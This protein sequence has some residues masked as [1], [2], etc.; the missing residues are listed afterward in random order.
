M[1]RARK[2]SESSRA[3]AP[4]KEA[5]VSAPAGGGS[6]PLSRRKRVAFTLVMSLVPLLFFALLEGGL[7]VFGYGGDYPLF[8]EADGFSHLLVQNRE[9]ARRYFVHQRNVPN[10]NADYFAREKP[11]GALR[12]VA[13]GESSTAGFPF[14]WG[15]AFPRILGNRL[16]AAYPEREV[17]VINTAMAAINSYTLLDFADEVIAIRP[18]AVVIYAGHNEYYG[19]LGAASSESLGGSPGVVRAFLSLRGFRT[20]QLLRDAAAAVQRGGARGNRPD[21]TLMA[22]MIGEQAV[23]IGGSTYRAG[24]RQF[25]ENM[26]RLLGRLRGAGVPVF[27]GTLASNER[28]QRPFVTVHSAEA[29]TSAWRAAIVAGESAMTGGD[30][31]RAAQS[32]ERAVQLDPAAA[33]GHYLYA[34]ALL[35]AGRR[36]AAHASFLRAKDLDALR[37]RAPETFNADLR[38][39][40]ARHG[41]RVVEVQAAL[42]AASPDGIIGRET[43]M[44][45]LHPNLDGYTRIADA[46]FDEVVAAG[47]AG[48]PRP[49][50]PGS[51]H[52]VV[53]PLDSI[54]G[55]LRLDQ[56]TRTWPFRPGEEQPF[57]AGTG[58]EA[59]VLELARAYY[60]DRLQW[61]EATFRLAAHYESAGRFERALLARHALVRAYPFVSQH[62]TALGSLQMRIAQERGRPE[63]LAMAESTFREALSRDSR[64]AMASSM[65]GALILNRGAAPEALP[66]LERAARLAPRD[67]QALYNL[68][69][70]YALTGRTSQARDAGRRVLELQPGHAGA[71]ALLASLPAGR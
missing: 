4:Q 41:A 22:R 46:F 49:T 63:M 27:V 14:Y 67:A 21:G 38:A 26:D 28:D 9:V 10:A 2:R 24:R 65:L 29:D 42:R 1:A 55:Y 12:V 37:F 18:D 36:G 17:E 57:R 48:A 3:G 69:G 6:A 16:R 30:A 43:M 50:A 44:E 47:V 33:E 31:T 19:A 52:R 34:R 13:L 51:E 61:Q 15:A 8:L 20:V 11:A 64:D 56:L 35:A 71:S 39:I 40:A 59:P 70:A 32:F 25:G 60:E 45:H 54:V 7:R 68:A 62:L 58:A 5:P 66:H 53:T 23:P